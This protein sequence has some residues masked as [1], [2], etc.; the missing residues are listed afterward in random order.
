V[1]KWEE[2]EEDRDE[3][4]EELEETLELDELARLELELVLLELAIKP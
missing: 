4:L 2:L 3:L 1:A